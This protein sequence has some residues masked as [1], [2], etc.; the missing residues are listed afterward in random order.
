[1][2][3]TGDDLKG[4]EGTNGRWGGK[5]REGRKREI[6]YWGGRGRIRNGKREGGKKRKEERAFPYFLIHNKH[7]VF[8]QNGRKD[9]R[10]S[11]HRCF[12]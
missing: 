3:R 2:C 4:R 8:Y 7:C 5:R 12:F 1:L 6:R 10:S 11:K 9:R